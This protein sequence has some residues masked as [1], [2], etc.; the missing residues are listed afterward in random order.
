MAI[1]GGKISGMEAIDRKSVKIQLIKVMFYS[2][3]LKLLDFVAKAEAELLK[4]E[5]EKEVKFI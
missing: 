5:A 4:A 3:R 1:L 2:F